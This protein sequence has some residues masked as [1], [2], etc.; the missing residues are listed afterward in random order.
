M[1]MLPSRRS[2]NK[3]VCCC[4]GLF[5]TSCVLVYN[6]RLALNVQIEN[7][8]I[9]HEQ[10]ATNL[11]N[12]R[13]TEDSKGLEQCKIH[14][15][16]TALDANWLRIVKKYKWLPE[17][18]LKDGVFA[19]EWYPTMDCPDAL[20]TLAW[21]DQAAGIVSCPPNATMWKFSQLSSIA[22]IKK[23]SSQKQLC[24]AKGRYTIERGWGLLCKNSLRLRP[25]R[26]EEA[27]D[28]ARGLLEKR[29][30]KNETKND[31][32]PP[33]ILLY[34]MD[35]VSRP[36]LYRS[37]KATQRS[38][39]A[40][41]NNATELGTN[42]YEFGRH[43]SVGGSSIRN[44]TPMLTGLLLEDIVANN[45][46]NE[47]YQTWIFEE[48]RRSG[49]I[50]YN[51]HNFCQ[52]N[53]NET[54]GA[55]Y[56]QNFPEYYFPF[57]MHDIGWF[58]SLYCLPYTGLEVPLPG[59]GRACARTPD[60]TECSGSDEN[61][62]NRMPCLGGRSRTTM[63]LEYYLH[64]RADHDELPSFGFAHDFDLHMTNVVDITMYDEDKA[65]ILPMLAEADVL[66]DTIVIFLS[67]HGNHMQIAAT[68]QGTL[69]YQLPFLYMFI[70]DSVLETH[71]G[72]REALESNQ[73]VLTS[74]RDVH[75]TMVDLM[76]GQ[77]LGDVDWWSEYGNHPDVGGSSLLS[78]IPYN[79]SCTDAGIPEGEC[80]CGSS[81]SYEI[82]EE[83]KAWKLM[84]K[85]HL[86]S[87][88]KYVNVELETHNLTSRNL[89]SSVC[90]ML[91]VDSLLSLTYRDTNPKMT[92]YTARFSIISPRSE[93][94][95]MFAT[96]SKGKKE[97][98]NAGVMIDTIIQTSQ[99][100]HWVEQCKD[101]VIVAGGSQHY[102]DCVHP[103]DG[104]WNLTL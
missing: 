34:M 31:G 37:L 24:D 97:F 92:G 6:N 45:E 71:R 49:Y 51:M 88:I 17:G 47:K 56:G 4:L 66:K 30:K 83:S 90:R 8:T 40:V 18:G 16:R 84:V 95:E 19:P 22:V 53:F 101:K 10:H 50:V 98:S 103:P 14:Q 20:K 52:R 42:V 60:S 100:S 41:K 68:T 38:I 15:N 99:F 86:P 55:K 63:M 79:R 28:R 27:I 1:W 5:I 65:R 69:E 85:K 39:E 76:G 74:P 35:A 80:I 89:T 33:H 26:N 81:P 78:P 87:L 21:V 12:P 32:H 93:P 62:M 7:I 75:A 13:E 9:K 82:K 91:E 61:N 25:K 29:Q 2:S 104:G 58:G 59:V 43:H 96:Y 57:Q 11:S 72:S 44:L 54:F 46:N 36:A 102:C 70:P 48:M 77:G 94:M 67:D 73:Q 3:I 64:A 23:T